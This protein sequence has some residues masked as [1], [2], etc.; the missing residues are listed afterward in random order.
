MAD[1]E[2]DYM[3]DSFLL[4]SPRSNP[5]LLPDRIAKQRKKEEKHK[6]L[7]EKNR[8][9]PV[10]V[11]EAEHREQGLSAALDSSNVGFA[12]LQKMGYKQGMGLGKEGVH[13]D[14]YT[15]LILETSCC[16]CCGHLKCRI[17]GDSASTVF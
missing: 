7:N 14:D 5:G 15:L 13:T 17:S 11:R 6:T 4:D 3:S 9:K 1:E 12:L 16:C 8:T 2:D 10:R